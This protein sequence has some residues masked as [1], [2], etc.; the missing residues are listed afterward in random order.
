MG[1]WR[2]GMGSWRV[3]RMGAGSWRV[4]GEWEGWE[5]EAEW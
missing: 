1:S 2:V 4:A 3:G 5:R